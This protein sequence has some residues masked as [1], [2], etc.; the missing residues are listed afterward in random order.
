[1]RCCAS[2]CRIGKVFYRQ[3]LYRQAGYRRSIF[4]SGI[5]YAD[6][7]ANLEYFFFTIAAW[8]IVWLHRKRPDPAIS[9]DH[10]KHTTNKHREE[11]LKPMT[12]PYH[13]T[14]AAMNGGAAGHEKYRP[15]AGPDLPDRTWPGNRIE[16]CLL[17]TSPSPRD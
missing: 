15:F 12:S 10:L 17:Y 3:T 2:L 6:I 5:R 7:G 4:T 16:T 9:G 13:A 11:D 14:D 8:R 1:M